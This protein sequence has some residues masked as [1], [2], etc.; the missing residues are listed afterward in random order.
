MELF[1]D[2]LL[3]NFRVIVALFVF[4]VGGD[5]TFCDLIHLLGTDLDFIDLS[6]TRKNRGMERL[7]HIRL[8]DG[9]IILESARNWL[10]HGMDHTEDLVAV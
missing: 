6:I 9:D 5:A 8:R 7:I 4:P 3:L 2:L 1:L 10:I